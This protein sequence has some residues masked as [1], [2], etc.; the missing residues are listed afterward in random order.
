MVG[1]LPAVREV[2]EGIPE[3]EDSKSKELADLTQLTPS[4]K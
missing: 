3:P 4:W 2:V 1:D